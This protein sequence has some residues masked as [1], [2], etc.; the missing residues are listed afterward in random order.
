MITAK[1]KMGDTRSR[2]LLMAG[3]SKHQITSSYTPLMDRAEPSA[4]NL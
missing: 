1:L 4:A 2:Y 3:L